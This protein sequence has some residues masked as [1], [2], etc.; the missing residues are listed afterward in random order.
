MSIGLVGT[1]GPIGEAT[2]EKWLEL[3]DKNLYTAKHSGRNKVIASDLT[4]GRR[5]DPAGT[6]RHHRTNR[7]RQSG[8]IPPPLTPP[9]RHLRFR[10]GTGSP[11]RS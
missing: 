7:D 9:T 5:L 11:R 1:D 2:P 3:A 8:L 6:D 10:T 4:T